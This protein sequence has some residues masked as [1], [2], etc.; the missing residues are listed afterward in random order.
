MELVQK[1]GGMIAPVWLV[2]LVMAVA[3]AAGMGWGVK[4]ELAVAE[5]EQVEGDQ[6]EVQREATEGV[7]AVEAVA[8][9]KGLS[10]H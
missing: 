10:R 6:R 1:L 3:E 4:A 7:V 8:A 5:R 2:S 9:E